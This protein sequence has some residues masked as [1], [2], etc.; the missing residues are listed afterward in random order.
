MNTF[1]NAIAKDLLVKYGNN[2]SVIVVVFP[3]KRASLFLN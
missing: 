1:L 2:L 3:I